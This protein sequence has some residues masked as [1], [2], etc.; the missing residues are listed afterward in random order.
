MKNNTQNNKLSQKILKVLEDKE[1]KPKAKW[2]FVL[3]NFLIWLITAL[4]L[5]LSSLAVSIIIYS[6]KNND[7][8]LQQKL[9]GGIFRFILISLPYAWLLFLILFIILIYTNFKQTK[10]GYKYKLSLIILISVLTSLILGFIFYTTGIAQAVE[11]KL[12]DKVPVYRK[13]HPMRI[14][15]QPKQGFLGGKI[16]KLENDKGFKIYDIENKEWNIMS[17]QMLNRYKMMINT[18]TRVKI[19]GEKLDNNIFKA[20]EIYPM[21]NERKMFFRRITQ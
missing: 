19:I 11:S 18:G 6:L 17:N 1:I 8:S 13:I 21:F 16:F 10:R 4:F 5:I 20:Q 3:K 12:I 14:W 15:Q 9:G 2:K 7:W